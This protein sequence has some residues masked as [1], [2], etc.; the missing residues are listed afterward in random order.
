VKYKLLN[1]E[2]IDLSPLPKKDLEFILHLQRRA[3]DDEDYFELECSICG[4]GAYPLKGSSRVTR[5][6]HDSLL[7]RVAE[8]VVDRVGLRQGVI[9]PDENDERVPTDEIVSVSEAADALR[10]SRSAV[11]K[12]AH[13]GRLKGKKIGK[14]WALLRRSVESYE[15]A[16]HRVE[17]GRAARQPASR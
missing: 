1:G 10:I 14:T 6:I 2:E 8:D 9:A 16:Q 7:F 3:I 17:A 5:A 13:A 4:K 12:A 15:V 11:L